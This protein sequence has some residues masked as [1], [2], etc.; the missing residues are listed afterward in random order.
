MSD[1]QKAVVVFLGLVAS[2]NAWQAHRWRVSSDIWR[3]SWCSIATASLGETPAVCL[4]ENTMVVP[5]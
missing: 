3:E 5:E 1:F 4:K 2:W